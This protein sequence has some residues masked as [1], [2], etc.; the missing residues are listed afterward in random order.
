MTDISAIGFFQ[1]AAGEISPRPQLPP[2]QEDALGH[3][4]FIE[5]RHRALQL[6]KNPVPGTT[7]WRGEAR[8]G[9]PHDALQH[10][11]VGLHW[12]VNPDSAFTPPPGHGQ[13]RMFW[14]GRVDDP[15]TQTIPRSHP[16]W[17]G[18]TRSMDHE[19]EVR[20]KPGSHV[21]IDGAYVWHGQDEP[22][23]HPIP[24]H[25][26]RTHPDWKWHPVGQ[27]AEV[28]NNGHIDYGHHDA[29]ASDAKMP[30]PWRG[31]DPHA[32][33]AHEHAAGNHYSNYPGHDLDD[34][35]WDAPEEH[36]DA[37]SNAIMT[38]GVVRDGWV[39][40]HELSHEDATNWLRWHPDRAGIEQRHSISRQATLAPDFEH[41]ETDT[42]SSIWPTRVKLKA[43]HPETGEEMGF[44]DYQVPRRKNNKITVHEL[45]THEDHRRKGVGSALMDEMQRRHPGTP[46]DHGDRT[47]DGKAWWK[48]Y[49]D[50]KRV[51]RGRT[52]ATLTTVAGA[53]SYARGEGEDWSDHQSRVRRGLSLGHLNYMQAREHGYTGDAREDTRDD[54]T[55][56]HS[57]GKGWQPLPQK[58]YHTTTDAAG[59]AAHGL[60]S[61]GELGQRNGHGLGGTPQWLSMTHREDN[62]HS[63]LDAL[64]EYHDHLNG[65]TTF[66]DLHRAAQNAEGAEKPF[67]DAFE[68]GVSG[69]HN[70][71]A[72]DSMRRG[73]R[74]EPGFATYTEAKEK[75]WTP[76]P[77][78]HKNFGVTKDGREVGTGW[79]RDPNVEERHDEY[80]AFSR[81]REWSG[82]GKPSV[83]FTSNDREAFAKKDPSNFAVLHLRP[84]PGAQGF[85]GGDKHEWRTATGDAVEVHGEPIRRQATLTTTAAVQD[86]DDIPSRF[87]NPHGHH[88]RARVGGYTNVEMVPRHEVER[89]ASQPTD[90]EHTKAVGGHVATSGEMEPLLLHYHPGS[91]QAYLG[92]GNHRLR[93]ARAL[94]MDHVPLRVQRSSSGLPGPGV[95][96]PQPHPAI[97]T[98]TH[99]PADI[100]PSHIGLT[101][102]DKPSIPKADLD[103][104]RLEYQ[105]TG[106]PRMAA[107]EKPC[108]CCGGTG[109]HDTGAECYHCDSGRTVPADSPDDVTCDGKTASTPVPD[110]HEPYKHHHDWLPRGHFFAPGEKGLDPRLFDE[111]DRMHPIVRQHLLS[112]LNSFWTPKYGDSWQSW[113][114]VYLTGSEASHWYGNND[115]DIL[116]GVDHEALN[117]HVDHFTGEPDDAVDAK[118]TDEL[119][120]GLNDD[121]RM[122][123]GPDGKETGPWESTFYV[124]P[125][126][127]DIKALKPYAAYDITRDEWAVEPVEVPDD[128]GPEKLPESTWDVFDALQKLIKAIAEL[129]DE[130]RERE[131]AA[132][133]DYL[134]ADRHSAFGPEGS[135]LYDPANATWKALDKAPGKPLQQLIDWKHAHDGTAA[136][137]LETAA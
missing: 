106:R 61:G 26:E 2:E 109:E 11:G 5:H 12:S 30:P 115:L 73:K 83:L 108:P 125:G 35:D 66:S 107:A 45:K 41:E 18:R 133:Y 59:V 46:I 36:S 16:S 98:G 130:V 42:G 105:L 92:E 129:P 7:I 94:G 32:V 25:P 37:H 97:A 116:I 113:A 17:D 121:A 118:L 72:Q 58:L 102:V 49:A 14:Q 96:V 123:P 100:H 79:E 80:G 85:P 114:R 101:A 31:A 8:E 111:N 67:H 24:M 23:G 39:K 81:A 90:P 62:A 33:A 127:Y 47:P 122:L 119:R 22:H 137:D 95:D 68:H 93:A 99:I 124:N 10:S 134:H 1:R 40:P 27:H 15:A 65:K 84:R 136:T 120:E 19:A 78:I 71:Y 89:Y 110:N 4:D 132:L 75:G 54:W 51:Q 3:P 87:L 29:P 63:M 117:Y 112:L 86:G 44:L 56:Q 82:N 55:G 28:Q 126:S 48:G 6:A 131:G 34:V 9:A 103:T 104:A 20:L 74:L 88:V 52:M 13:R 53:E 38:D 69:G 64:H 60:K 91:G 43:L 57:E 76:H 21:H 135:G 77:T 70:E 128:F 50:G